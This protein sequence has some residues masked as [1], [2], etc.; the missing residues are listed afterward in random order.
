MSKSSAKISAIFNAKADIASSIEYQIE[1]CKNSIES[2]KKDCI[3]EDGNLT[4]PEWTKESIAIYEL[5]I[6]IWES[7]LKQI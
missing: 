6:E 7:I 3:D 2:M 4:I 1:S 5:K